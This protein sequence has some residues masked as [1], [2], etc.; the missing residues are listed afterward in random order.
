MY[1]SKIHIQNYRNFGDFT[2]EFH[3]GLN[4]IIGANNSGKT[5][6]LHAINLLNSPSDISVNDFNKNLLLQYSKLYSDAAPSIIIE[7]NICHRIYENDTNDES[8]IR[9]LPFLGIKG[10]EENRYEHDGIAEYNISAQI[11]AV[12]A[13]DTKYLEE[14]KRAVSNEAKDFE[15]Y[16]LVLK[17][18]VDNHY[19]WNYTN[20]ISS[21]KLPQIR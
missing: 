4:V 3:K 20:G 18:F 8:I 7:Y 1:I 16:L 10:F 14:Y 2:M 15:T 21:P 6:L 5:G 11:K 19:S 13:L 9:L 17:R 12:Y